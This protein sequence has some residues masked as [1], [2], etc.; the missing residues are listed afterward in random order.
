MNVAIISNL[1]SRGFQP[2]ERNSQIQ[3][4]G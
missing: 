1:Y 4:Q 2:R 3:F